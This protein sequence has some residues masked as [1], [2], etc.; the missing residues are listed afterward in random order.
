MWVKGITYYGIEF[1]K[2]CEVFQVNHIHK[3]RATVQV[4]YCIN[5]P[6]TGLYYTYKDNSDPGDGERIEGEKQIKFD[7]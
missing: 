4:M 3:Q 1:Y 6:R 2:Y 5:Y 7:Q